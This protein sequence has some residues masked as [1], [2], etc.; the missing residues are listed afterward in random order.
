MKTLFAVFLAVLMAASPAFSDTTVRTLS[1]N[2]TIVPTITAGAYSAGDAVGGKMT[3]PSATASRKTAVLSTVVIVDEADQGA[4]LDLVC[5]NQSFTATSDNVALAISD[6][7]AQN[8]IAWVSIGASDYVDV[9]GAKVAVI[10]NIGQLVTTSGGRDIHCQM[11]TTG[12][13]TYAA[14]DDLRVTLGFLQD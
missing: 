5:F 14:T 3:F 4:A 2:V 6:A 13:P 1:K 9:G 12:T 10:A 8:L 11:K 7:D